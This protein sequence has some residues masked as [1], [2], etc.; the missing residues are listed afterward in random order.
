MKF[1]YLAVIFVIIMLPIILVMS[2]YVQTQTDVMKRQGEYRTY[3]GDATHD[4]IKAFQINTTNSYYSSVSDSKIRDIEAAV[5]AFYNSLTANLNYNKSDL[6]AYVP[7]IV[8][9]LYDGYYIYGKRYNVY[10][11]PTINESGE[12]TNMT[13]NTDTEDI[14]E[15]DL[16]EYGLKPFVYYSCQYYKDTRNNFIVNYTL[17]NFISIYGTING[18][19]ENVSG[20]LIQIDPNQEFDGNYKGIRLD[21][22]EREDLREYLMF[23]SQNE[24]FSDGDYQYVVHQ[25]Q[26]VYI[27]GNV[28]EE[29]ENRYFWYDQGVAHS[30]QG[31]TTRVAIKKTIDEVNSS[32]EYY[33]EAYE[34]S[35]WVYENLRD[36]KQEN[37]RT[38]V[39]KADGK[40]E[41]TTGGENLEFD[42]GDEKIFDISKD[43]ENLAS[44][45]N[46]HRIAVIKN[47]I[48][49]NLVA[50]IN[51]Y[52]SNASSFSYAL[53]QL[54]EEDWEKVVNNVCMISFM[55]GMPIGTKYFND[56]VVIPND[57]NNEFVDNDALYLLTNDG[58]YHLAN[59]PYL[60]EDLDNQ[61][62][63]VGGYINTAF[64]RQT[65]EQTKI[66]D[67]ETGEEK[68]ITYYYY[69]HV[70]DDD[71]D[72]DHEHY[73]SYTP[74]YQCLVNSSGRYDLDDDI[75]YNTTGRITRE[76]KSYD[77][78]ILRKKYF[79]IFG[80]EKNNL[81]KTNR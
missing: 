7:A 32:Y 20:H 71:P 77:I 30:I 55:Q 54:R 73:T 52:N 10:E 74:C 21:E 39:R 22:N 78:S 13:I 45:F 35:K 5:N 17:D 67:E 57:K 19:Y 43:P 56:Y 38:V 2:F 31:V 18:K 51:S 79:T 53:P 15:P 65:V 26:K 1:Q 44:T 34:F 14:T 36:I 47:A 70:Y 37:I 69:R 61:N 41:V 80:R 12:L 76:E 68:K 66:V 46:Q 6:Q 48:E 33:K 11:E 42:A 72:P 23:S 40:I 4:A 27:N 62:S 25:N 59:C 9:T 63:I 24:T 58:K 8:F 60:V 81:Y 50:A 75:I 49:T 29:D 28:P 64:Q 16:Y 3:L